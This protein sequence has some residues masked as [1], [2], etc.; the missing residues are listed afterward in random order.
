[1]CNLD[2]YE[3]SILFLYNYFK[4]S[5]SKGDKTIPVQGIQS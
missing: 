5:Q 2:L 3:N 4:P 1:M